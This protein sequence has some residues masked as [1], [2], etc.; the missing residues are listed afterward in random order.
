MYGYPCFVDEEIKS[1][2]KLNMLVKI[3]NKLNHTHQK[4][5][6]SKLISEII[7][8]FLKGGKK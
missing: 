1:P 5:S 2:G 8:V 3:S 6:T 4:S 7:K